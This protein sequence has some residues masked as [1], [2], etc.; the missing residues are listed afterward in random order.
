MSIAI[1]SD[2][3]IQHGG[4]ETYILQL[5]EC[6]LS[7]GDQV[8]V[9]TTKLDRSLDILKNN[10]L[11]IIVQ[12]LSFFPKKLRHAPYYYFLRKHLENHSFDLI[13]A[14]NAP[15]SPGIGVCC[16]TYLGD[17]KASSW[18]RKINPLN[19]TRIIYEKK[20][21][22]GSRILVAQSS[23]SKQELINL[24]NIAPEKIKLIPPVSSFNQFKWKN[25]NSINKY[26]NKYNLSP[27]KTNFLFVSTG[28]KR[29][30]LQIIIDALKILNNKSI[31][32]YVAGKQRDKFEYI[33]NIKYLGYVNNI[34][35]LY[36]AC[37]VNL[38]P[39]FYE[40][41]GG[42]VIESLLCGTPSILSK[43]VGS[44]DLINP[45]FGTVLE[46]LDA[47]TLAKAM[48]DY[49][50]EDNLVLSKSSVYKLLN[51]H[52]NHPMKLKELAK[53]AL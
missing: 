7:Q 1:L 28:H 15:Y 22:T 53:N 18:H 10:N 52:E 35:E 32:V 3:L 41:F 26:R 5:I 51:E 25:E 31:A 46:N 20:K 23:N 27:T 9:Y 47:T 13:I 21:Y 33:N 24:Y 12:N 49:I 8:T 42:T 37:D 44:K 2:R 40:P 48:N 43:H 19:L 50:T 39:S 4:T 36:H 30:G 38:L 45:S 6:Y 16:G 11:N 34:Q 29:K 14:V 17:T